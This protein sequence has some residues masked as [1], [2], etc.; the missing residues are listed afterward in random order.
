MNKRNQR[1]AKEIKQMFRWQTKK[2]QNVI[3]KRFSHLKEKTRG[4]KR[5]QDKNLNYCKSIWGSGLCRGSLKLEQQLCRCRRGP[6]SMGGGPERG[7]VVGPKP[8][9]KSL[10]PRYYFPL[11]GAA[12]KHILLSCRT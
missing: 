7:G 9:Q 8:R 5:G 1:R 3:I 12:I 11:A 10:R 2:G 4:T 6:F